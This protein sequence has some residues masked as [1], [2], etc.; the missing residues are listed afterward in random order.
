LQ[1][2]QFL[3]TNWYEL[4]VLTREHILI[5]LISSAAAVASGLPLGVL[6]TR[7]RRWEGPV[8]GIANVMQTVPSLALFGLLIPLPFIGGIGARTAIIALALYAIL[9][10][11]R[12]TVTGIAGIDPKLRGSPA[13]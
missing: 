1:V 2:G 12:H 7:F 13:A 6:L 5:V 3:E 10:D 8:L 11:L 4:F 9:P